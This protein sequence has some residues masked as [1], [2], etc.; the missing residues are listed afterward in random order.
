MQYCATKS[1][2]PLPREGKAPH[3]RFSVLYMS[4]R[5]RCVSLDARY[6]V[7]G[8]PESWYAVRRFS[9][10][11]KQIPYFK[12]RLGRS[13]DILHPAMLESRSGHALTDFPEVKAAPIAKARRFGELERKSRRQNASQR[14]D[15]N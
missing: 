10:A 15:P 4:T 12:I 13:G 14:K 8:R 5:F 11:A 3:P 9:A 2:R 6:T 1:G 7:V